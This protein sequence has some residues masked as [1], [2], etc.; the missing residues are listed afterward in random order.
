MSASFRFLLG[1]SGTPALA[2]TNRTGD[3][4]LFIRLLRVRGVE[5]QLFDARSG[6]AGPPEPDTAREPGTASGAGYAGVCATWGS[7]TTPTPADGVSDAS[8]G[9]GA[10]TKPQMRIVCHEVKFKEDLCVVF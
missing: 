3:C 2:V 9:V 4:R 7:G 6:S 1:S 10:N 8:G 5:A